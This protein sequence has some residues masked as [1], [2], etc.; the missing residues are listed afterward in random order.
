ME[1]WKHGAF[2]FLFAFSFCQ[3]ISV[4]FRLSF[5]HRESSSIYIC[6]YLMEEGAKLEIYD[7]KVEKEQILMELNHPSICNDPSRGM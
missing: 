5:S 3:N 1:A 4:V 6:K 7:P 2:V